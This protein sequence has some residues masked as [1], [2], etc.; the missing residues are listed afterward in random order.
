LG[1]TDGANSQGADLLSSQ[2]A[3]VYMPDFLKGDYAT[4]DM[5]SGTD[6]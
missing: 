2:G 6:E 1:I 5:F 3:R 4:A